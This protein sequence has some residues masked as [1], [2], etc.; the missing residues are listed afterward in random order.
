MADYNKTKKYWMQVKEDWFDDEAIKW[1]EE[2]PSGEY[3]SNFYMK[4]CLKSIRLNGFLIRKVGDMFIPY[5]IQALSDLTRVPARIIKPAMRVLEQIGLIKIMDDGAIFLSIVQSMIGSTT[6]GAERKALQRDRQQAD[7]AGDI[8]GDTCPPQLTTNN[9]Q[10]TTDKLKK[11][12]KPQAATFDDIINEFTQFEP[13]R[14]ALGEFIQI[15]KLIKAP[16]TNSSLTKLLTNQNTGLFD[17]CGGDNKLATEIVNQSVMNSWRGFFPLREN[18]SG[19][20]QPGQKQT[21]NPFINL[22]MR[23]GE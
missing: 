13:L 22:A 3:Y 23:G 15:R 19:Q 10:L 17:L 20:A 12:R 11:E 4:L 5:D 2:Q 18:K 6:I 8:E 7:K 16:L 21:S 1:L 9:L 14:K